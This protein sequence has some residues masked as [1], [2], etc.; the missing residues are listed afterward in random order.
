M[1]C[2]YAEF[3][4]AYAEL[5]ECPHGNTTGSCLMVIVMEIV[6]VA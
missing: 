6:I 1:Y 4:P 5:I 2:M 3:R